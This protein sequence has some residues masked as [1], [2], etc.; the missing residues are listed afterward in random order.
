MSNLS[1]NRYAVIHEHNEAREDLAR[2][3]VVSGV[4]IERFNE[5]S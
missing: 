5:G 2:Y 1:F 4:D 3:L